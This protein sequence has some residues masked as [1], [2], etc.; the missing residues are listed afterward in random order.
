MTNKK[1]AIYAASLVCQNEKSHVFYNIQV[2][3]VDRDKNQWQ[4]TSQNGEIDT[5]RRWET[6]KAILG[7]RAAKKKMQETIAAKMAGCGE[8]EYR[9]TDKVMIPAEIKMMT[10]HEIEE[11]T[12][13]TEKKNTQRASINGDDPEI[14]ILIADDTIAAII[15]PESTKESTL[16]HADGR[17][18]LDGNELPANDSLAKSARRLGE[19]FKLSGIILEGLFSAFDDLQDR[20]DAETYTQRLAGIEDLLI[21]PVR[22]IKLHPVHRTAEE[23]SAAVEQAAIQGSNV[24]FITLNENRK[25]GIVHNYPSME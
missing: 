22:M 6:D 23:K 10:K 5:I 2:I 11:I 18:M 4:I 17:V 13:E 19:D 21:I 14:Q 12:G 16:E 7:L 20:T 8:R 25:D 15:I 24:K 1:R 3:E 9:H